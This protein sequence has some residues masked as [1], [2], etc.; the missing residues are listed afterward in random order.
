MKELEE[1]T[2]LKAEVCANAKEFSDTSSTS[3]VIKRLD[4]LWTTLWTKLQKQFDN[5]HS[6]HLLSQPSR[7]S[8]FSI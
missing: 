3:E 2:L 1:N 6:S 8:I 5:A 7:F 4:H